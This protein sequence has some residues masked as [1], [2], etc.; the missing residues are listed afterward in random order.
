[1]LFHNELSNYLNQN[2]N[3]RTLSKICL[4]TMLNGYIGSNASTSLNRDVS[5]FIFHRN[6][7]LNFIEVTTSSPRNLEDFTLTLTFDKMSSSVSL[8]IRYEKSTLWVKFQ[9]AWNICLYNVVYIIIKILSL[10]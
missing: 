3:I 2:Y 10:I 6:A 4:N 1:M 5:G 9:L 8:H 7:I